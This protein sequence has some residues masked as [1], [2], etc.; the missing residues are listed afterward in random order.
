MGA[1]AAAHTHFSQGIALDDPQPHH[2][3]VYLYGQDAGVVCHS[4]AARALW[5]LGAPE[6]G[7]TQNQEAVRLA[8][9]VA[10][11]FSLT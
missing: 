8:Q 9:Q 11:P 2:K 6:Q 5:S 7:L 1:G 4:H 3:L 10:H